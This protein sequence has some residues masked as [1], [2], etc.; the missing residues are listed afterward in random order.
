MKVKYVGPSVAVDIP[1]LGLTVERDGIIDVDEGAAT[2]L[3][4]QADWEIVKSTKDA[5]SSTPTPTEG[6]QS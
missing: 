5:K 1:S 2:A 4:L 6:N 3:A